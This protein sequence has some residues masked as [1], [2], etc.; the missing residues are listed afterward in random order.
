MEADKIIITNK[1]RCRDCYRCLRACPVKAIRMKDGQ[2]YVDQQR[3]I[4]CG[5]CV[6]ECPQ[7]AKSIRSDYERAANFIADGFYTIVS[8]APSFASIYNGWKLKRIIAALRR[9]GFNYISET[10]SGAQ[11]TAQLTAELLTD[12]NNKNK[13]II[14]SACP[15]VVNYIEKYRHEILH[16]LSP[17]VSPVIAHARLLIDKFIKNKKRIEFKIVFIGPCAAK[18][19]EAER[20]EFTEMI[21]AVLTFD[22]LNEWLVRENI[23]LNECEE[24]EF[25][26]TPPAAARLFPLEGGL[27]RT[28]A[29]KTDM[30][31]SEVLAISGFDEIKNAFDNIAAHTGPGVKIKIIEPLFCVKGCINGP[32]AILSDKTDIFKR[33]TDIIEYQESNKGTKLKLK[34]SVSNFK[35]VY[36]KLNIPGKEGITEDEIKN[37]LEKTGKLNPEDEL[38]CGACGYNSC[39]DKAVAVIR[40]MAELEMCMPYMRK[41][42][43][44]R[45]D[46]IIETS[47]NGIIILDEK[48]HIISM[49]EAFKKMFMCSEVI[50]GKKIS[51]LIDPAN[52]EKL[53]AGG[54]SKIEIIE[55][56]PAYNIT[57][58]EILYEL[59]GEK[60]YAGIFVNVTNLETSQKRLDD[61]KSQTVQQASELLE[62]QVDMAQKMAKFLGEYTARGEELVKNLLK[63]SETESKTPDISNGSGR[64][65]DF[66]DVIRK[67]GIKN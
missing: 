67:G 34:I 58:H 53:S 8:L 18:K 25:D 20:V 35:T 9:L 32:G 22:E 60:Q 19:K 1:A 48:L 36:S 28:A 13:T 6:R 24:S 37:I 61:I 39:R 3:C 54:S 66:K 56:H 14:C 44:R 4:L 23:N 17:V 30:L 51:Y 7:K 49:N 45:T 29:L 15:A 31:D 16:T 40:G 47:P 10:A 63:I 26:D 12:E 27:I 64:D 42:A 43:E 5:T 38:N 62:H 21:D 2:A 11:I 41:M 33:K 52:F 59:P 55:K 50:I 65:M 57:C 46:K